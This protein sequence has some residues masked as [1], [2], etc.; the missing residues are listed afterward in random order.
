MNI[1]KL[2]PAFCL[3][4]LLMPELAFAEAP[5]DLEA[6]PWLYL[7]DNAPPAPEETVA[8][9][10]VVGDV[11]L[12]RGVAA[13]P[14]PFADSAGWLGA[15]DLI[16]SNLESTIG[17]E[18]IC[19]NDPAR[20]P[21]CLRAPVTAVDSLRA[22]G[23]DLLGLAN[24]HAL[25]FGPAGLAETMVR[26]Q[27]AGMTP[28][29][30]GASVR[31]VIRE[32]KGIRLAFLAFNAVPDPD[33]QAAGLRPLAWNEAQALTAITS[34]QTQAEAVLVFIHWGREYQP[35][36]TA[37]QIDAARKM[38]KAGA[39]VI[40]GHHP[41]LIQEVKVTAAGQLIAYS[42]GNFV[43]D[44]G[45]AD[46]DRGLALRLF[47]D[48]NGLRAAQALPVRAGSRPHLLPPAEA[49]WL[50]QPRRLGFTCDSETCRP[51]DDPLQVSRSGL[52]WGGQI[53]LTGDGLPEKVRRS[54]EQI[55]IYSQGVEV[56]R[57]GADWR[58]VDL[59]LGDPNDDGRWEAILALWK[60]DERGQLR[61]HPFIVGYR[62]GI[63]RDIW[64]GSAVT[65]PIHEVELGDIDGDGAQE[66]LVLEGSGEQRT[67]SAWDWHGWGF[68]LF[69]RSRPGQYSDLI[70]VP[71]ERPLMSVKVLSGIFSKRCKLCRRTD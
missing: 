24:N 68:S 71:G 32:V 22:A 21:Y 10:I 14:A 56:W 28:V 46:T 48:R 52:F 36:A 47:F 31:P 57:G 64:G 55:I 70:F 8:E 40:I 53:D 34:A 67:L 39:D 45:I 37:F 59:A 19:V 61:N 54:G 41:H 18:G 17:I 49:E 2:L 60:P 5:P 38:L 4:L 29:G 1:L 26:L 51:V 9:V 69:W 33:D 13:E 7:R 35:Q 15:A 65:R 50:R 25:D 20:Q 11:M 62:W 3:V 6:Y 63:Y 44:Q 16:L 23:F 66:L 42:L 27:R 58:V 30:T 12:G 43:F